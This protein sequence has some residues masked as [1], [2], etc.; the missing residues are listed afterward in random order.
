MIT[1]FQFFSKNRESIRSSRCTTA[2]SVN[3][4]GGNSKKFLIRMF[5]FKFCFMG[6]GLRFK[7]SRKIEMALKGLSGARKK[8]KVTINVPLFKKVRDIIFFVGQ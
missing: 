4:I 7:F 5:Y 6:I 2:V 8:M 1:A 3:N